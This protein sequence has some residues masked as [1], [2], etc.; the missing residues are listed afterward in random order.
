MLAG[1]R[2]GRRQRAHR[3][4]RRRAAIATTPDRLDERVPPP[5][6]DVGADHARR[7]AVR[8]A[9]GAACVARAGGGARCR[10]RLS[11]PPRPTGIP[12]SALP[13]PFPVGAYAAQLR[14]RLRERRP[15]AAL[16]RGRG[17]SARPR[18]G[19]LRAARRRRRACPARCGAT[20]STRS[21]CR[22]RWPT[23]R[24]SWSAAAPTTTRARAP[25]RRRSPSH[26]DRPARGGRGRPARPA[27]RAA[28]PPRR[29]GPV[30]AAEAPRAPARCRAASASSPARTARRATTC[31]PACAAA[32]GRAGWCGPSRPSRTATP[33]R[34]ITRGA[35]ATSPPLAEVE[36]DRSS[37]AAAARWPTCSRS[38]TRR[39]AAPSRCCAC[40]VIASVGHHTDRTLHRRRRRRAPARPRPTPPRRR[41]RVHC[42]EARAA[43]AAAPA[44]LARTPGARCSSAPARWRALVP[45]ARRPRRA[46]ARAAA[47]AAARA[48]RRRR[49]PR[50]AGARAPRARLR[51]APQGARRDAERAAGRRCRPPPRPSAP[52][53]PSAARRDLE[54]LRARASPRHDPE[55]TLERGYALVED[56]RGGD[57][58]TSAEAARAAGGRVSACASATAR[59]P[60]PSA[61][62]SETR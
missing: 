8:R 27:R 61:K 37:R 36:V 5:T 28:P 60:S 50:R 57:V 34:A 20:T 12:G 4:A 33:R 53:A 3:R 43:L 39:C 35:A 7:R 30:R 41:C 62:M 52:R 18:A 9:T 32:A 46:P 31:S 14:E 26:V 16:R 51:P 19:L 6:R 29:R 48:A 49:A 56:E 21:G 2:R 13:G 25:R 22:A 10:S 11:R 54:R 23:A 17:T 42:A 55:R 47:P 45:R 44:R 38:A 40:P 15:R 59:R 24:R 1:D 58:V